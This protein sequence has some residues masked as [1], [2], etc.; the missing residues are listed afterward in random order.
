[1]TFAKTPLAFLLSLTV[2]LATPAIAAE[3][4]KNAN[5]PGILDA[6]A[7]FEQLKKLAGEWDSVSKSAEGA[8]D[9]T[10]RKSVTKFRLMANGSTVIATFYGGT[11][12]EMISVFHMDGPDTIVHTHYCALGNQPRMKFQKS[13]VPGEIKFIFDGGS[14]IDVNKDLHVHDT[15][16]RFI[17]D[18]LVETEFSAWQDGKESGIRKGTLTRK[19]KQLTAAK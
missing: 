1:M 18:D 12:M 11:P 15:K 14:N 3:D 8:Q 6:E 9:T 7:A 10:P 2:I 13:K 19:K 4:A 16:F 5:K 17:N